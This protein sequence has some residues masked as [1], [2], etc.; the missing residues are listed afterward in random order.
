[1]RDLAAA[2]SQR[3]LQLAVNVQRGLVEEPLVSS[4]GGASHAP[5]EWLCP[6]H[7]G[8]YRE[9]KDLDAMKA[10]GVPAS[11]QHTLVDFW[12][13]RGPAWDGLARSANGELLLIEAK[14]NIPE[15]VSGR[16]QAGPESLRKITERLR[17]VREFLAPKST[18]E[19]AHTFSHYAS[20]LAFLYFLRHMNQLPARLVFV[21][22]VNARDV[23]GPTARVEWESA[24][25]L[26]YAALGL[27]R[28][29]PLSPF[30]HN[31]F[32]DAGELER[33]AA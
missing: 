32:I 19:W 8:G 18:A 24:L 12:P 3:W 29:H 7:S 1:M 4:L 20:R 28:R 26:M 5:L 23:R 31:L 33:A 30:I 14:A 6:L 25:T 2:G 13:R 17:E 27:P 22:F 16:T 21:F 15:L 11:V 10:L 9:C